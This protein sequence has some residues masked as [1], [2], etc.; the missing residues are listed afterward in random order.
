MKS[1]NEEEITV[2]E[3]H[4]SKFGVIDMTFGLK[5]DI[6]TI[7]GNL[8]YKHKHNQDEVVP[9][10]LSKFLNRKNSLFDLLIETCC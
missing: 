7:I 3:Q 9:F 5:K 1:G 2:Q 8:C 10:C 6:I 4:K